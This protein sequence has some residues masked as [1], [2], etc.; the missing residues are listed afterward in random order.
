MPMLM[1]AWEASWTWVALLLAA[2][3]LL[4]I[5]EIFIPSHGILTFLSITSFVAAV[6]VGFLMGTTPGVVTLFAVLIL[7]PFLIYVLLR[8]W[9]H[10]PVARRLI[11]SGPTGVAKAGD[12]AHYDPKAL[13]GR[14]GVTKTMLRPSGKMVL[15]G[16]PIDCV[17]EGDLVPAGRK[18]KILAVEGARVVVRPVEESEKT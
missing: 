17:T 8:V 3:I 5:A 1:L 14:I 6:V 11:L 9:P 4:A 7:T 10:T 15:D 13:V 12:L 16:R 18:V 2:G